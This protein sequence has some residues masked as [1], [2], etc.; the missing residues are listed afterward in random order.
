MGIIYVFTHFYSTLTFSSDFPYNMERK[1]PAELQ[2]ENYEVLPYVIF[3]DS[4]SMERPVKPAN[5]LS[6]LGKSAQC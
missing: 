2:Q 6:V 3:S 5:L 1:L 4:L